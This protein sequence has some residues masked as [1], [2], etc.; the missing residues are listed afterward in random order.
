MLTNKRVSKDTVDYYIPPPY[1]KA[2]RG[3]SRQKQRR[4]DGF[5]AVVVES[6][7]SSI[8]FAKLNSLRLCVCHLLGKLKC[9]FNMAASSRLFSWL[10]SC[11]AHLHSLAKVFLFSFITYSPFCTAIDRSMTEMFRLLLTSY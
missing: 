7:R 3:K 10:H 4:V 6:R 11:L 5:I 1:C 8:F 2:A 9:V